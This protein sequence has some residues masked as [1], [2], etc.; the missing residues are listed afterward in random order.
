MG[1]HPAHA[2]VAA[3]VPAAA[4]AAAAPLALRPAPPGTAHLREFVYGHPIRCPA[5]DKLT[6]PRDMRIVVGCFREHV[7]AH[8]RRGCPGH[9]ILAAA[10]ERHQCPVCEHGGGAVGGNLELLL[11]H[12]RLHGGVREVQVQQT[13]EPSAPPAPTTDQISAMCYAMAHS[14]N[15]PGVMEY[16]DMGADPNLGGDDGYTPLM[17]AAQHGHEV[18]R[19]L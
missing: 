18:R 13:A 19:E 1:N 15:L 6:R 10:L 12:M 8:A 5:C 11:N 14:G 3:P 4:A 16:L 9:G 7:R 2:P 17:A